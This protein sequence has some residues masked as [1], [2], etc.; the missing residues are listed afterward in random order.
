MG[1][2]K[3]GVEFHGMRFVTEGNLML[4]EQLSSSFINL[5]SGLWCTKLE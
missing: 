2:N 4:P 5:G 1:A 3:M